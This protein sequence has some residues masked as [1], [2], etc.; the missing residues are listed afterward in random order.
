M[1]FEIIGRIND[2]Q[3]IAAGRRIREHRRL[4]R[5]YGPARWRKR[6][7]VATIRL[8]DG[9]V[10]RAELHWYEAIGIGRREF[11]IKRFLSDRP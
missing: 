10:R 5:R 3:T 11:K 7:G 8:A 9:S 1:N 6:S 2:A 4:V